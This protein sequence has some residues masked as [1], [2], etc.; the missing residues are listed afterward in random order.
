MVELKET[1][2]GKDMNLTFYDFCVQT[3][4]DLGAPQVW[5]ADAAFTAFK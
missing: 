2:E 3:K 4:R 1:Y 5:K